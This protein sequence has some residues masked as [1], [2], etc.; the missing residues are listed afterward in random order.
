M[1][2][3]KIL[4]SFSI[5]FLLNGC[6]EDPQFIMTKVKTLGFVDYVQDGALVSGSFEDGNKIYAKLI[7]ICYGKNPNPTIDNFTA[8][9]DSNILDDGEYSCK[10]VNLEDSTKYYAKAFA[11]NLYGVIYGEETSFISLSKPKVNT[12]KITE[13]STNQLVIECE[14]TSIGTGDMNMLGICFSQTHKEPTVGV[15]SC[16]LV[17][18]IDKGKYIVNL[19][20][21]PVSKTYIRAFARNFA[22]V[23]Y[24]ET[25]DF[26]TSDFPDNNERE[27]VDLGLTSRTLWATCNVGATKPEDYGDYFAWGETTTKSTYDWKTYKWCNGKNTNLT[28]YCTSSSYGTVDDKTVL[29]LSD[30]AANVKWGGDWRMPTIEEQE[31]LL[32]E[33]NWKWTTQNGIKGYNVVS[34]IN[35]NSIFLPASGYRYES[36]LYKLGSWGMM[37]SSSLSDPSENSLHIGFDSDSLDY[38]HD[39]RAAGFTI[40][41][42]LS[43]CI[44][45]SIFFNSN[46]GEGT[47]QSIISK[48]P[49]FTIPENQFTRS[50]Y[51]FTGW[52]TKADGTGDSYS[53][54]QIIQLSNNM[55]LY[56][57]WE[58][59]ETNEEPSEDSTYN[60]NFDS[61]K[62][63][64][65][66]QSITVDYVEQISIPESQFI[67]NCH[68]FK[69]WNE[70][71][72]GTGT[73]YEVGQKI[74]IGKDI[75][76]Y[77]QWERQT[78]TI[79][80]DPNGGEG[81]AFDASVEC[82]CLY[83]K[84]NTFTRE[85]Y[86]FVG[87]NTKADGTGDSYPGNV[88][89]AVENNM[90]LY[91]QWERQTYTISYDPNVGE[92]EV[93]VVIVEEGSDVYIDEIRFGNECH[94]FIAWNTKSDGTGTS[95]EVGQKISIGKDITLYAQW[96]RQT[97]TISYDPNGGEGE[98]FDASVEC[99]C[100]YYKKNTF[101]REGYTFVGW[102]TKADGTGDSYSDHQ[103]LLVENNITLYAQWE[104][105]FVFSFNPNGGNGEVYGVIVEEGSEVYID[106]IR[107]GNECHNF[108]GW[109]T[110]SDGTGTSY[111]VGQKISISKD[112]T[113]YAQWKL[114][115]YTISYNSNG[116]YGEGTIYDENV[117]CGSTVTLKENIFTRDGYTFVG[118]NT[119]PD[120][121]G[122]IYTESQD[123][124]LMKDMTLYAQWEKT[125]VLSYNPNGGNGEM[126]N[127]ISQN[128]EFI[129]ISTNTFT[130]D[131]YYFI[132]WNTKENGSGTTY[133]VGQEIQI[134]DDI[135]LYAQ[136]V[137]YVDLG[138]PSGT[139]WATMNV[140]AYTPE[141]IGSKF[142][143]GETEPK[144]SY[145][146]SNYKWCYGTYDSMNKYYSNYGFGTFD[147]KTTLDLEDDAAYV[148]WGEDWRMPT[149][150]EMKELYSNY[151]YWTQT[152]ENG[153]LGYK[154]TSKVNGNSIFLPY[155]HN[156]EY[157]YYWSNNRSYFSS[158][159]ADCLEFYYFRG[160][161][162]EIEEKERY[163]AYPI[164]PVLR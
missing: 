156:S 83:Y 77:A 70:K 20:V 104:K 84:K 12:L 142:A 129:K 32:I 133:K 34:K 65:S 49:N 76:L 19:S 115:T 163:N 101:T 43:A 159:K 158:Y 151:C 48:T 71:S 5:L 137:T 136:W 7:G 98:A 124:E 86:T 2:I 132:G 121:T 24:G 4:I 122:V 59:E 11:Y 66:M 67:K 78:Y 94:N 114:Q 68:A 112:M 58:E 15:D 113:L 63:E 125:F 22:G 62:G 27:F 90:T 157:G 162:V 161:I 148:N 145:S 74:S 1:K 82:G 10:L 81:E 40:R 100:L 35:G 55:I 153:R 89:F 117:D 37:W 110:E 160:N 130:R 144:E 69:N 102:N 91:A 38:Y 13:T 31:E 152:S 116:G 109:N 18:K 45:Y 54:G 57:Q 26:T 85:G 53:V 79:S 73:S 21:N 149:S 103:E 139:L 147:N 150:E 72:D 138:L 143:W 119:E 99:G 118:W 42:I 14:L 146:F 135:T 123:I 52:N 23:G 126:S 108:I 75:T 30:D 46:G 41:P 93:Y 6:L 29:E 56:A 16:I 106:E 44:T 51:N 97:Y 120:G 141:G 154:I 39:D 111:E 36:S 164:R 47:M 9:R 95:Y 107:F 17:E 127:I 50:G 134:V 33:C 61:N 3:F 88:E 28:K 128:G 92:G 80:Y 140:G 25:L 60:V 105:V 87:W 131:N 155:T 64:G 8:L 96:E